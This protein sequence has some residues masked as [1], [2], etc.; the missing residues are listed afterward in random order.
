ML[1]HVLTQVSVLE[2]KRETCE[3]PSGSNIMSQYFSTSKA[4]LPMEQSKYKTSGWIFYFM[5]SHVP[6]TPI[7]NQTES[8]PLPR[9]SVLC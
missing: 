8:L 3:H 5:Q 9:G 7:F 1:V 4:P 6:P 2:D